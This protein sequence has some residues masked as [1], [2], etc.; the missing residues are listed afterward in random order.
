MGGGGGMG[1]RVDKLLG[2]S[3]NKF[4]QENF[5]KFGFNT[6]DCISHIFKVEKQNIE[7][8]KEESCHCLI[9]WKNMYNTGLKLRAS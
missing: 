6:L 5:R 8:L 7:Q 4:P 2:W 3:G 1:V 9:F